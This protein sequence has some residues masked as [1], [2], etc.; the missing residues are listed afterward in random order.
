LVSEGEV[1]E[2]VLGA[3]DGESGVGAVG[4]LFDADGPD[5]A[6]KIIVATTPATANAAI[7]GRIRTSE[8]GAPMDEKI[9]SR[10]KRRSMKQ[11]RAPK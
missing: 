2:G 10:R 1:G 8:E 3:V 4:A 6:R 5:V 11:T 9:G 7:A